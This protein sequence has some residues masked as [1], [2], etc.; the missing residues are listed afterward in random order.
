MFRLI[1]TCASAHPLVLPVHWDVKTRVRRYTMRKRP[2]TKKTLQTGQSVMKCFIDFALTYQF[3]HSKPY[4]TKIFTEADHNHHY[5]LLFFFSW[6]A[7]PTTR[8][9]IWA[10][11]IGS[12]VG[13]LTIYAANQTMIQ[14]YLAIQDPTNSQKYTSCVW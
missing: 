3:R 14:R 4:A 1:S 10:L 6:S 5:W 2:H 8:H 9:S 12:F 7:D 13:Q 11:F